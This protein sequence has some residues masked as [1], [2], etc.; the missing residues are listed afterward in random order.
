MESSGVYNTLI[1]VIDDPKFPEVDC[2]L[3]KGCHIG[4]EDLGA[5]T[6]LVEAQEFLNRYYRNYKCQLVRSTDE[7]GEF[8]FLNSYGQLMGQRRLPVQTMK[9]GIALGYMISDPEYIDRQILIERLIATLKMLLGEDRYLYDFAPRFRGRN[10]DK[11]EATALKAVETAVR[12]LSDLGFVNFP[13]REPKVISVLSPIYRFLEPIRGVGRLDE[14]LE[15]LIK[16][17]V[18]EDLDEYVDEDQEYEDGGDQ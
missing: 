8:F 4:H 9:V 1:D 17:G 7:V 12:Q 14:A 5:Y 11:D 15:R 3:R 18:V 6:F 13:R 2:L 16:Q 10:T